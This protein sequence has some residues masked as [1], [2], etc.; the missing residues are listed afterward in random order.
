MYSLVELSSRKA[1]ESPI[2]FRA[3]IAAVDFIASGSALANIRPGQKPQLYTI[4]L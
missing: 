1:E 2:A 4:S 3:T